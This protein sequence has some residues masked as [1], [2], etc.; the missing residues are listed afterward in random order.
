[1][2]AD[3]YARLGVSR[4]ASEE[5]IKKAY[6]KAALKHHPDRNNGSEA[7]ATKFKEISEAFEVLSDK[8]KRNIYDQLG[9]EGL[10]GAPPP[11]GSGGSSFNSGSFPGGG[12]SGFPG[13]TTFTF[14]SSSNG[15]GGGRYQPAD[16]NRIFEQ[17][18]KMGGGGLGNMFGGM[19]VDSDDEGHSFFSG[20]MP[21]GMPRGSQFSKSRRGSFNS[22]PETPRESHEIT[23]PL[24][25][26]LEELYEGVTKRLKVSRKLS[27]GQG[28]EKVLEIKVLPGWKSGTKIRFPRA[29][30]ENA[31]G[32]TQ[33]LVFV[34]EE[35]PHP[36]IARDGSDLIVK[37]RIPLVDALVNSGGT[38]QIEHLDG[39]KLTVSLPS[40][41]IK[42]GSESRIP[43]EG[44]PL[45]KGGTV[46]N[47]GDFIVRWEVDFPDRLTS[48]QKEGIRKVL[49]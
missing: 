24:K 40:N 43:G 37:E 27:N 19:D 30:N 3:Y 38:R 11:P 17:F 26:S 36:R 47:K 16:P 15:P 48:S 33:D 18:F 35:K 20:G 25:V 2:G 28:E 22:T 10:K 45:R 31:A 7:S 39:R 44:M 29:G 32:E 34:V 21:G 49:G 41:V 46:Q 14:S 4:D 1:M 9:E 42:P 6:R 12:F 23:R 13:G 8:Q 5:D